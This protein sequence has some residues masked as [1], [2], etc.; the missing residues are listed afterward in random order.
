MRCKK[1]TNNMTISEKELM[2][3]LLKLADYYWMLFRENAQTKFLPRDRETED[4]N[5]NTFDD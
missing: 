2:I 4:K 5:V 1:S 3:I